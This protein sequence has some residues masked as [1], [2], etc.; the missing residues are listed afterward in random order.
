VRVLLLA[1]RLLALAG[2]LALALLLLQIRN[3]GLPLPVI[4]VNPVSTLVVALDE[5]NL[6]EAQE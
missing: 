5:P 6:V 4:G 2:G 1:E 3:A